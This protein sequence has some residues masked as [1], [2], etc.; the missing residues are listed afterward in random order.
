MKA[1]ISISSTAS[2]LQNHNI[3]KEVYLD[4]SYN[5]HPLG[6]LLSIL[7]SR[8]T[9][10]QPA[11]IPA[12]FIPPKSTHLPRKSNPTFYPDPPTQALK[13]GPPLPGAA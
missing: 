2:S 8:K 6:L 9:A 11:R 13:S 12:S 4:T 5:F 7:C 3:Y 1:N 10:V